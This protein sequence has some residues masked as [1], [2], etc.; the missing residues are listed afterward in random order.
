MTLKGAPPILRKPSQM[1]RGFLIFSSDF[2]WRCRHLKRNQTLWC[3]RH[4]YPDAQHR[5]LCSYPMHDFN[6]HSDAWTKSY[7][8]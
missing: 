6:R 8:L 1:L 5:C 4:P 2:V 7:D 3:Q